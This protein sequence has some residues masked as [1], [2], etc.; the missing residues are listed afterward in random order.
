MAGPVFKNED[1]GIAF[2]VGSELRQKA[3]AALLSMREDGT[4]DMIKSKWFGDAAHSAGQ[5]G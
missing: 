4:Y 3:D 5:P 1:Y 2:R